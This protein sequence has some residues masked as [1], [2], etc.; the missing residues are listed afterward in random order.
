M[1]SRRYPALAVQGDTLGAWSIRT[2]W[3]LALAKETNNAKL[4]ALCEELKQ[5]I[6]R[7]VDRYNRVCREEG[8]TGLWG[9]A[10]GPENEVRS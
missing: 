6:D 4:I 3:I 1:P 5:Q 8:G 10:T 2:G 7:G 9:D